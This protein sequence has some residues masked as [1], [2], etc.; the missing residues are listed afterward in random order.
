[1]QLAA[2]IF[3]VVEKNKV[4]AR[5]GGVIKRKSG[6]GNWSSDPAGE[7]FLWSRFGCGEHTRKKRVKMK[8]WVEGIR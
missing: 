2:S 8:H 7:M 1:M 5:N 6:L 3:S 4:C